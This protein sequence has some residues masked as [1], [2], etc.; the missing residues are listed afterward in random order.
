M[1]SQVLSGSSNPSYTNNTGQN[2]RIVINYMR[3]IAESSNTIPNPNPITITLNWAGISETAYFDAIG[4]NLA[5]ITPPTIVGNTTATFRKSSEKSS[6]GIRT[7]Y[8]DSFSTIRGSVPVENIR[9]VTSGGQ[10][11]NAVSGTGIA[12]GG[13]TTEVVV[14][15][16]AGSLPTELM[17]APGQT[18]SAICGIYNIVVIPEDG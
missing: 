2:V 6:R 17:L 3:G 16:G 13:A 7:Y 1:A 10:S 11:N 5:F 9:A 18:F 15:S 14:F 8:D 12:W 4:R